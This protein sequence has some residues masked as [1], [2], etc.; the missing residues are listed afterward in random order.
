MARWSEIAGI[1]AKEASY[2]AR[3]RAGVRGSRLAGLVG[4]GLVRSNV[5]GA[6]LFTGM[7]LFF[8]IG[9][10]FDQRLVVPMLGILGLVELLV[11]AFATA[12]TVHVVL[13]E[14]LLEPLSILPVT[15]SDIRLALLGVGVY[16]GGLSM[17]CAVVPGALLV[18][19]KR[20]AW[21][22]A[23]WGALEAVAL[24]LLA[25]GVGYLLGA[26]GP[27]YT[28]SRISRALQTVAWLLFFGFGL[29]FQLLPP[30]AA[31]F[32]GEV[33]VP[34]WLLLI[35]PFSFPAAAMGVRESALA[36]LAFSALSVAVL[37]AGAGRMWIA[38]SSGRFAL[39]SSPPA[40]RWSL[41]VGRLQPLK[42]DLRLLAMNPRMLASTVYYAVIGPALVVAPMLADVFTGN[43]G[44]GRF[45]PAIGL[46]F[47]GVGGAGV[48]YLYALDAEGARLLYHLP[49]TRGEVAR[50]KALTLIVAVSPIVL[51]VGAVGAL[52]GGMLTGLEAVLTYGLTLL[53]SAM[54]NSTILAK[55]LPREP[56][57]WTQETFSKGTLGL[58]MLAE[59]V[60]F[61]AAAAAAVVPA[62]LF[63]GAG[64]DLL[65]TAAAL[66]ESTFTL[67]L[68]WKWTSRLRDPV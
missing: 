58:L 11:G 46:F 23:L 17:I 52:S 1:L 42:K 49:L 13:T 67:Y 18:A 59:F 65:S 20:G 61:G 2:R 63:G 14:G 27:K 36:S 16:W 5:L 44:I 30:Q 62:V 33:G 31:G 57:A 10:V 38:A 35:P 66:V 34:R 6:L 21:A 54:L 8:C 4:R 7:S 68:G 45:L 41:T 9:A 3:R 15:E 50:Q 12:S 32:V 47:G 25:F 60:V 40:G 43:S 22:V 29:L 24:L 37:R 55:R 28:R 19:V 39:P 64:S 48:Y 51:L 53:G 26:L 56:S